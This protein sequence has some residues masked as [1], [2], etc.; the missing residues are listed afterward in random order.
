MNAVAAL[1]IGVIILIIGVINPI[2]CVIGVTN[3]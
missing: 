2:I 3:E 1:K